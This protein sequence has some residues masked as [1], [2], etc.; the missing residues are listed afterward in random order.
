MSSL[1]KKLM[2]NVFYK[3]TV[4]KDVSFSTEDISLSSEAY[5]G[6]IFGP[7]RI[8]H[9]S[10]KKRTINIIGFVMYKRQLVNPSRLLV[11]PYFF[12]FSGY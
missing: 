12:S 7:E 3:N 9:P 4:S 6:N 11:F 5:E 1:G 2:R 10:Q 8:Q